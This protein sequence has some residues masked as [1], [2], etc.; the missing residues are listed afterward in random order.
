M[1]RF[2]V[3]HWMRSHSLPRLP[4]SSAMKEKPLSTSSAFKSDKWKPTLEPLSRWGLREKVVATTLP[5]AE[6]L[7]EPLPC[8]LEVTGVAAMPL[9]AV[10]GRGTGQHPW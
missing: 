3:I 10:G 9:E 4:A 6:L 2:L 5:A 8:F 7:N 1:L